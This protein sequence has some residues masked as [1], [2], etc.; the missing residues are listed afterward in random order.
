MVLLQP[1]S[2]V[3]NWALQD[4]I[5]PV[6]GQNNVLVPPVQQ[7][8]Y[9]WQRLAFPPRQWFNWLGRLAANWIE[10]FKQNDPKTTTILASG[11][12]GVPIKICDTSRSSILRV[13]IN[14]TDE[15]FATSV[16]AGV[17]N[18]YSPSSSNR[19]I[20]PIPFGYYDTGST[21]DFN[22]QNTHLT[23]SDI[24]NATGQITVTTNTASGGPF[25]IIAIQSFTG[26]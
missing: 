3:P 5:D 12:Y 11:N 10:Y 20:N 6:S 7:Q 21:A 13:Y 26:V 2:A 17:C 18:P 9:G 16:F 1:P 15:G 8:Q 25:Q 22:I 14:D 4:Q 24:N 19:R 23:V